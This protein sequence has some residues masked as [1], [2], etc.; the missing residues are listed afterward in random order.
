VKT[1]FIRL[2][3]TAILCATGGSHLFAAEKIKSE[4][5]VSV[6]KISTRG[7]GIIKS[8]GWY[9]VRNFVAFDVS[10]T[11]TEEEYPI[12][13]NLSFNLPVMERIVPFVTGGA[14]MSFKSGLIKNLGGGLKFRVLK[15]T[16]IIAEYRAYFR[17]GKATRS[18]HY[19]GI[20][21]SYLFDFP[22]SE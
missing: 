12:S 20:G 6:G 21:L 19:F 11:I 8:M 15:R 5:N 13:G 3:L 4:I 10:I 17:S 9:L 7:I 18:Y 2:A 14:G 22:T 16:G 1:K